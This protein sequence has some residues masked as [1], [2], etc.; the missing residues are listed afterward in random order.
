MR[1][2]V[3]ELAEGGEDESTPFSISLPSAVLSHV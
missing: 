2:E 1:E 3:D